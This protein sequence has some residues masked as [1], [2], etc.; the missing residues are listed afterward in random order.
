[1]I[2]DARASALLLRPLSPLGEGEP[3]RGSARSWTRVPGLYC[4]DPSPRKGEGLG[5]GRH[6]PLVLT[7]R[8]ASGAFAHRHERAAGFAVLGSRG[9]GEGDRARAAQ[10]SDDLDDESLD[11]RHQLRER[12][13]PALEL[14][15]GELPFAGELWALHR[16]VDDVDERD[17]LLGRVQ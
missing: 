8:S 11:A 4:W 10:V 9:S 16:F 12:S 7:G 2:L 6:P 14:L 13:L 15:E 17:T 3:G 1:M 5:E